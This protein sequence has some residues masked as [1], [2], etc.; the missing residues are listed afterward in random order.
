MTIDDATPDT[1]AL[2]RR[3]L[4]AGTAADNTVRSPALPFSGSANAPTADAEHAASSEETAQTQASAADYA[5]VGTAFDDI[6]AALASDTAHDHHDAHG[7]PVHWADDERTATA[8]TWLDVH[9]VEESTRSADLDTVTMREPGA[10]LLADARLRPALLHARW[11]V[12]FGAFAALVVAYAATVLLWPLH[13]VPPTVEAVEVPAVVSELATPTWPAVGSAGIGIAGVS[14]TSSAADAVSIASVTK[15]VTALMVLD[16]MPLQLGEQ[17]PEFAFN[18]SDSVDYWDYRRGDQSALDV[19]VDGV[20]TEYQLL[21]GTLLGSANNYADRLAREIWGS[22]AS[23]ADAA[24]TWLADHGMTGITI[25]TPSGFDEGNVAT[26]DALLRLGERAMQNPV[27]AEIVGTVSADI[28]GAG[29]VANTNGMLADP[30]VVGIKTGTLEG[31]SMLTAKDVAIGGTTVRLFAAVL[32]QSSNDE[33]LAVTRSLFA[34]VETAL[35]D[36][37]TTVPAGT[38]VGEVETL[39]G[40][41]VDLVTDEDATVLLW[42]GASADAAT[43]LALGDEREAGDQAGSLSVTGPVDAVEVSVSLEDEVSGPSPW[44]RLTHPLELLGVVAD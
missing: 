38:V 3:E 42:N 21:Q 4:R 34:E 6:E 12:P 11:L 16:R 26:P 20:L 27:F 10:N 22:D 17:G 13:E 39:W 23:F 14:S 36:T 43:T 24:A 19:P 30:G 1:G 37:P 40:T 44:W 8:F 2:T 15:V 18:Y 7:T 9:A 29:L 25:V 31:W 35:Q 28:P 5:A 33:R 32:N 41:N